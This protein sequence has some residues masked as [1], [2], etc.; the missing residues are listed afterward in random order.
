MQLNSTLNALAVP[1]RVL[2]VVAVLG[3]IVYSF[4]DLLSPSS[5]DTSDQPDELVQ[6]PTVNVRDIIRAELF[7]SAEEDDTFDYDSIAETTLNLTLKAIVYNEGTPD[8]S[9]ARI[10]QGT[11]RPERY[12]LGDR[13]AGVANVDEIRRDRIILQRSGNRELLA[14]DTSY[15][16]FES[17]EVLEP[18]SPAPAPSGY[19]DPRELNGDEA[20]ESAPSDSDTEG[21]GNGDDVSTTQ[22]NKARD[23]YETYK[24]KL[25]E[26]P[27]AVLEEWGMEPVSSTSAEGYQI[28]EDLASKLGLRK[29][30]ILKS[31]NG[32]QVGNVEQDL[33]NLIQDLDASSATLSVQRGE[34]TIKLEIQLDQ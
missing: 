14:F 31:V 26:D 19:I 12:R 9:I 17:V 33:A 1:L 3:V 7:G 27:N 15:E 18:P 11:Q 25:E 23:L 4:Y 13:I 2:I 32:K 6:Q 29:G 10:S 8:Q 24:E 30:D 16:I 28:N 21:N 20:V 22:S 34:E 5:E